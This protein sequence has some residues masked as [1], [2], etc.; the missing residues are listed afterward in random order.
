[1]R[2]KKGGPNTQKPLV[3]LSPL[4]AA[5]NVKSLQ[6]ETSQ[7]VQCCG[8]CS[9]RESQTPEP[10]FQLASVMERLWLKKDRLPFN[11]RVEGSIFVFSVYVSLRKMHF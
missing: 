4:P 5:A 2:Q 11:H 10:P 7:D 6:A 3:P 9:M 8:F 1:M